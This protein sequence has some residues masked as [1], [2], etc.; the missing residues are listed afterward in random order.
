MSDNA[1]L[2]YGEVLHKMVVSAALVSRLHIMEQAIEAAQKGEDFHPILRRLDD[3]ARFQLTFSELEQV[4]AKLEKVMDTYSQL[5]SEDSVEKA[6]WSD[7]ETGQ[8]E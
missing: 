1:E 2:T 6:V 3:Y 4:P 8:Q 5:C 7:L